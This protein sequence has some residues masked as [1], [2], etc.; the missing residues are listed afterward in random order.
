MI[1]VSV[2]V[3]AALSLHVTGDADLATA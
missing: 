3:F 1:L 2:F